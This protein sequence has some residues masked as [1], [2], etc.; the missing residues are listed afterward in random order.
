MTA[1]P[2]PLAVVALLAAT[3]TSVS[4]RAGQADVTTLRITLFRL[5]RRPPV[6]GTNPMDGTPSWEAVWPH[7]VPV[8]AMT[9]AT[10]GVLT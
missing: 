7:F 4:G 2:V 3:V 5:S 6:A 8:G 10:E 9:G 1:T